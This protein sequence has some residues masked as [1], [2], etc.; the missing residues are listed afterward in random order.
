[1]NFVRIKVANGFAYVNADH[2]VQIKEFRESFEN[3]AEIMF[4]CPGR[5]GHPHT[6]YSPEK[7]EEIVEKICGFEGGYL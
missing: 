3:D 6:I 4:D 7:P 5:N 2:I 1:M